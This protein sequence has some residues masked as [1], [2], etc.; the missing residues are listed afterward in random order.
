M[1]LGVLSIWGILNFHFTLGNKAVVYLA[2][3]KFAW[4]D[5]S[6][7]KHQVEIPTK[8]GPIKIEIG[9]GAA[10]VISSPCPNK[11]CVKTGIIR[12]SHE[13]IVCLPAQMLLV[14]EGDASEQKAGGSD[15]ITY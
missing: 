15:A 11:I 14:L 6:G 7:E 9:A 12:H 8:I 1:L 13:E 5:I 2:N 10:R 3:K 4:Y